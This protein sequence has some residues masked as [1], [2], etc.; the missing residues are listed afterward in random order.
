MAGCTRAL[1]RAVLLLGDRQ[2]LHDVAELGRGADVVGGDVADAFTRHVARDDARAER[3]RRDDR[4]LRGRV[5]PVDV[6]GRVGL[7]VAELLRLRDR[8]GEG[9]AFLGHPREHVVGR[10]VDDACHPADPLADQ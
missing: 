9:A 6:G 7:R 5:E 8:G 3:D 4:R 1:D 2:Q 10:A